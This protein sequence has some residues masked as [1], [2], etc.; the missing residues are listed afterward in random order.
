MKHILTINDAI[1]ISKKLRNQNKTVVLA[2]GC[3]DIL[4]PGH[5]AFIEKAKEKGDILIILLESDE[6]IKRTKGENRPIHVQQERAMM[7]QA[8]RFVDYIVLLPFFTEN[9][10]YD[11]LI[12][13]LKPH[14]IAVTA[15]DPNI[16]HKKR[17][18]EKSGAEVV[19]V[20]GYIPNKST[21]KLM[22]VLTKEF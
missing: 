9:M 19:E 15:N 14:I 13:T 22:E 8:L 4:H 5:I 21:S 11:N 1:K 2:G 17:Q 12:I 16:I 18:A 3:F 7:V 20:I 10:Q 6:K